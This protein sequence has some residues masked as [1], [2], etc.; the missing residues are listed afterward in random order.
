MEQAVKL[1]TLKSPLQRAPNR[2]QTLGR[3][4]ATERMRGRA[5]VDRRARWLETH[6]LC[7]HCEAADKV[8]ASVTVD[9]IKPLWDGGADDYETNG[10]SLCR[11]CHDVKSKAEAA[12]RAARGG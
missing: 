12:D 1:T 5:A 7:V 6:P 2:L 8:T 3:P 10:Q 11:P 4:Q 9:H